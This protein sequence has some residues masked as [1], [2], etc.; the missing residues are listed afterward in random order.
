MPLMTR[1]LI[2]VMS[3]KTRFIFKMSLMTIVFLGCVSYNQI[4]DVVRVII[5]VE[6]TILDKE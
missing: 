6:L 1:Q 3:D 2:F 5:R 4:I